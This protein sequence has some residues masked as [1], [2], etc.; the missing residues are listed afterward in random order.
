L[1]RELFGDY[2]RQLFAVD[3]AGISEQTVREELDLIG[4]EVLPA[5]RRELGSQ[6]AA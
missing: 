1:Q 4:A 5:L 3:L 2:Q 6:A